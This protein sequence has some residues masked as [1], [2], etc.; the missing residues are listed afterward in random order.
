MTTILGLNSDAM[1]CVIDRLTGLDYWHDRCLTSVTLTCHA[2]LPL[3]RR[4]LAKEHVHE[5]HYCLALRLVRTWQKLSVSVFVRL[6]P[7]VPPQRP[8]F[9]LK[10]RDDL[11]A[12]NV[13]GTAAHFA[14]ALFELTKGL[15]GKHEFHTDEAHSPARFQ[16]RDE[17]AMKT[18]LAI[19]QHDMLKIMEKALLFECIR[20]SGQEDS[21]RLDC[22]DV[23]TVHA[24]DLYSAIV[25]SDS[26]QPL[27]S[28]MGKVQ[29]SQHAGATTHYHAPDIGVSLDAQ[30]AIVSALARRAGIPKFDASFTKLAWWV[31]IQRASQ[32]I[33]FASL[34]ATSGIDPN[35]PTPQFDDDEMEDSGGAGDAFVYDSDDSCDDSDSG[36]DGDGGDGECDSDAGY[37]T[38]SDFSDD[39]DG[40][41]NNYDERDEPDEPDDEGPFRKDK[42]KSS[43]MVDF[44]KARAAKRRRTCR[45]DPVLHD[46][47]NIPSEWHF[48]AHHYVIS[49]SAKCFQWAY[50]RM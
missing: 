9:E 10:A 38:H 45:F 46:G 6:S 23:P 13:S 1:Q 21:V 18:F 4:A 44:A 36:D 24:T 42:P 33:A 3:G 40:D 47:E 34:I 12:V 14:C 11:N 20:A 32:L 43:D 5:R 49:P 16:I 19:V 30:L 28:F 17:E 27:E 29:W 41:Y 35:D 15:D 26:P 8:L 50:G 22:N 39:D 48:K 31:L 2:W 7:D 37:G 25:S